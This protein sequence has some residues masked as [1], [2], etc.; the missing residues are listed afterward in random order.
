VPNKRRLK[1]LPRVIILAGREAFQNLAVE[2]A[3]S[4][5][6]SVPSICISM[7]RGDSRGRLLAADTGLQHGIAISRKPRPDLMFRR[8]VKRFKG[9][10]NLNNEISIR[11][12]RQ[13]K[14]SRLMF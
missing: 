12:A 9:G 7:E 10:D 1:A 4:Y 11:L 6:K 14:A 5:T 13:T 8:Q 2:V 3:K